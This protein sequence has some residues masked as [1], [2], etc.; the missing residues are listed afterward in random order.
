MNILIFSSM[1]PMKNIEN[2]D[3][4][5][6]HY[7]AREW[8]KLGHNV[9]VVHNYLT[10]SKLYSFYSGRI[11]KRPIIN[12]CTTYSIDG[13]E[14][15][16]VPIKRYIPKSLLFLK[17]DLISAKK[18]ILPFISNK[19]FVPDVFVVHFPTTQWDIIKLLV[20]NLPCKPIPV[21]HNFDLKSPK[22]LVSIIEES[23]LIGV[24]SQSIQ[25]EIENI[26]KGNIKVFHVISGAPDYIF[27]AHKGYKNSR[28]KEI[29]YVGK[30]IPKKKID[31]TIKALAKLKET[32]EFVFRIIGEGRMENK[33]K[34][35]VNDLNMNDRIIFMGSMTRN[36]VINY[37]VQS[38]CF[39]MVSSPETFGLVYIEAMACGCFVIGSKGQGI[40]GVIKDGINGFLAE[41]NN[42]DELTKKIEQYFDMTDDK[43]M[44]IL[45]RSY[46]TANQYKESSV[47]EDYLDKIISNYVEVN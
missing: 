38:D 33:L 45:N 5:A 26:Y 32:Y 7:F 22:K 20:E 16:L 10:L 23:D 3:T 6:I 17:K 14:I 19:S 12:K 35:L 37:M 24:R 41:P 18:C 34:S 28:I 29:L 36:E 4:R 46:S 47:A 8:V 39:I 21:F 13:V 11:K 15:L 30:L 43:R 40:D 27:N 42:V 44:E 2:K 25:Q 1:Y 31:I 9:K